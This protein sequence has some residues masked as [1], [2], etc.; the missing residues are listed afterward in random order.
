M[1]CE[2]R[3]AWHKGWGNVGG[4]MDMTPGS[5]WASLIDDVRIYDR[6]VKP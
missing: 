6:A 2:A 4:D 5:F 1:P 3:G